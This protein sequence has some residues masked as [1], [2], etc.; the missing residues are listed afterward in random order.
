MYTISDVVVMG[1]AH[2]IILS[3]VKCLSFLDDSDLM[4]FLPEEFFDSID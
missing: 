4:T 2:E 1:E 3:D